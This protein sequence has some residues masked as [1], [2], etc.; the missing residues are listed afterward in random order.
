MINFVISNLCFIKW[1]KIFINVTFYLS[2]L[3]WIK[4]SYF[5]V[6]KLFYVYLSKCAKFTLFVLEWTKMV[7]FVAAF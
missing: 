1:T 2:F 6:I 4:L 5:H 7:I 3:G